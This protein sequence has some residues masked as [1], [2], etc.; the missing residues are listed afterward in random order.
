MAGWG[1]FLRERVREASKTNAGNPVFAGS[2]GG[3]K[4]QSP[5]R[6]LSSLSCCNKSLSPDILGDEVTPLPQVQ[7]LHPEGQSKGPGLLLP[8]SALTDFGRGSDGLDAEWQQ[9]VLALG[10]V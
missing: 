2:P 6:D 9:Q 7:G 1:S 8:L 5:L 10:N 3:H 4:A